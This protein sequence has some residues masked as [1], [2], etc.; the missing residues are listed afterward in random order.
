MNKF[1]PHQLNP[2]ISILYCKSRKRKVQILKKNRRLDNGQGA[3]IYFMSC[4]NGNMVQAW[5]ENG[6]KKQLNITSRWT[7]FIR[8]TM[9]F[10][11]YTSFWYPKKLWVEA[12]TYFSEC[13]PQFA[14]ALK[15]VG[16]NLLLNNLIMES[17]Y[18][19]SMSYKHAP[20]PRYNPSIHPASQAALVQFKLLIV[21]SIPFYLS[22]ITVIGVKSI[23]N[24]QI[25]H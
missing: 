6:S 8:Y 16:V 4:G 24:Y 13:T 12:H 9:L 10:C 18:N 22:L 20:Y 19:R 1:N 25:G 2:F 11:Y 15:R 5:S 21:H 23:L 17:P 3:H 7:I 14:F